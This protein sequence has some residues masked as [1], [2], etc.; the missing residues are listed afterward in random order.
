[1]RRRGHRVYIVAPSD[2]AL[3]GRCR[4]EGVPYYPLGFHG[5]ARYT[6]F[7]RMWAFLRRL[8]PA[9][10]CTHSSKDSWSTLPAARLANVPCVIRFRQISLP[11]RPKW[12]NRLLYRVLCDHVI[13]TAAC[14]KKDIVA[15]SRVP[16]EHVSVLPTGIEMPEGLPDPDRARRF[17]QRELDLGKETRFVGAVGMLRSDKG[18][19]YLLRAWDLIAR[20]HPQYHL[21]IVGD[22]PDSNKLQRLRDDLHARGQVYLVGYRENP[23]LYLRAF[24]LAVQ[25]SVRNEGIPQVILQA[26]A[27][28][29]PVVGTRVGGIPE[30]ISD[31]LGSLLVD[32]RQPEQL[33]DAIRRTISRR[34]LSQ[35]RIDQLKRKLQ[36]KYSLDQMGRATLQLYRSLLR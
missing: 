9:I 17:L 31:E 3:A 24:D 23:W 30:V 26:Q 13:T 29:V 35:N 15:T 20:D 12:S 34:P 36:E 1:M 19:A 28:G 11:I 22:G 27:S 4:R 25:P 16:N 6:A 8:R 33:A 18:H 14:I 5:Y 7:F 21:V 32:A 10:V 2:S